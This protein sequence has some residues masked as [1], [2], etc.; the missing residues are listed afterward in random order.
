MMGVT[1]VADVVGMADVAKTY[2]LDPA[3]VE[4]RL[5]LSPGPTTI[6]AYLTDTSQAEQFLCAEHAIAGQRRRTQG[7]NSFAALRAP[8]ETGLAESLPGQPL[9]HL[10]SPYYG[11]ELRT[12]CTS[13]AMMTVSSLYSPSTGSGNW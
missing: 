1:S 10:C 8:N 7:R 5:M 13:S 2:Y 11:V 3:D 6:V 9:Y 12:T 4:I